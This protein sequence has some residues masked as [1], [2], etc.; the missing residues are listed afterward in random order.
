MS[1]GNFFTIDLEDWFHG[2]YA[3]PPQRHATSTVVDDT[4]RLLDLLDARRVRAT[5]FCLGQVAAAHPSL[6]R[7][8]HAAGHEIASHSQNHRLAYQ[9]SPAEF[10][11]DVV[12]C[13]T[14]LEDLCGERVVGYRAPSWSITS[15]NLWALEVLEGLGFT[16]DSSIFPIKTY[17]YGIR[18][19]PRAPYLPRVGGVTSSLVEIPPATYRTLGMT[20]GFGGGFFLR[21]LPLGVQLRW[22]RRMNARGERFTLYVHPREVGTRRQP[23]LSLSAKEHLIYY[24]AIGRTRAKLDAFLGRFACVRIRDFVSAERG[25]LPVLSLSD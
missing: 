11:A 14:R 17:L 2:N 9:Q 15:A 7:R 1:L 8:I 5:V 3:G 22:A 21:A 23:R 16:Y 13:K 20:V 24:W 25:G 19:A 4:A 12:E 18:D 10:R 6:I